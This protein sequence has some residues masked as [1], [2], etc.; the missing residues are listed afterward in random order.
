[1]D[2]RSVNQ[3]S[4]RICSQ[5][6][7]VCILAIV[8]QDPTIFIDEL[9]HQIYLGTK[10]YAN[11]SIVGKLLKRAGLPKK[12][13]HRWHSNRNVIEQARFIR[14]ACQYPSDEFVWMDKTGSQVRHAQRRS[15][16]VS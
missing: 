9:Q 3:P 6:D 5:D 8:A 7:L 14:L 13:V 4:L 12:E 16:G 11:V 1:M 2:G 15:A 10:K